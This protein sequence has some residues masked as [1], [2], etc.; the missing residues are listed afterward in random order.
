MT[1]HYSIHSMKLSYNNRDE[2]LRRLPDLKLSYENIHK[3]VFSEMYFLIPKGKKHLAW[4]T[5]FE[6]KKVCIFI[7]LNQGA[8]KSIKDMYIVPQVF[9]KK[10][11]LGT[12]FYGTLFTMNE[13]K[14]Y[15]IAMKWQKDNLTLI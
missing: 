11:V 12:I 7:E 4:F 13:K 1:S 15:S 6:D 8:D 2:L 14:F 3:K 10:M 5:Y 9:D